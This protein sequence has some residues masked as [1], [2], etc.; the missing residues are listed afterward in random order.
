MAA[1]VS[2]KAAKQFL[3]ERKVDYSDC[4]ERNELLQRFASVK[5]NVD[6]AIIEKAKMKANG[7]FKRQSHAASVRLYT[8]ALALTCKLHASDEEG[9]TA[10]MALL[11][12]NRSIAIC[13]LLSTA[14]L[15]DA[16]LC[17]HLDAKFM[18]GHARLAAACL[19][20]DYEPP[21]R[22]TPVHAT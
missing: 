4:F 16:Q 12:A 17:V 21:R 3:D 18:K 20:W 1:S 22:T 6:K 11:L 19:L 5:I 15:E 8:E 9:A 13:S 7:A 2:V 10:R 14:A